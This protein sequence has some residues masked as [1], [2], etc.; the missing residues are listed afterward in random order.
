MRRPLSIRTASLSA[1]RLPLRDRWLSAAG[2]CAQREGW[3]LRLESEDGRCGY[4]DCAPLA[5]IGTE[6]LA[7]AEAALGE[8]LKGII[9]ASVDTALAALQRPT[10]THTPAVHCALECAL[11]DLQAQAIN[12]PL[13][14]YLAPSAGDEVIVNAAL[15]SPMQ[16]DDQSILKVC[17]Q[18]FSVL[19][20][21]VGNAPLD[22]E[23]ERLC[24]IVALLPP[25]V[26]LRLDAN[27]AWSEAEATRFIAHCADWPIDLF[28][29]PL[30]DAHPNALQRL[31]ASCAF[32][33][34]LDE[35]W[36]G[37]VALDTFFS[38]PTVR[39]LVLKPPRIG[40]LLPALALARRASAAGIECIVTS[41]IDSACGVLAAAQLAAAVASETGS[42]LAHGLATCSWLAEDLGDAPVISEGRL[43]LPSAAG[44]GF[45]PS[46]ND[47]FR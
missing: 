33:L 32:P 46:R 37:T 30:A 41:S 36:P 23:L 4:G 6:S 20:F 11:L 22:D 24:H 8:R 5:L 19:K 9:G 38:A 42:Q 2:G 40:G 12:L 21:K 7:Q 15:G 45:V 25:G 18:G 16:V 14:R 28:E 1:Y 27:R 31:Q 35:S 39:C 47:G 17:A 44:L 34:A 10:T 29:E 26:Q 13:R 43:Q 3:L